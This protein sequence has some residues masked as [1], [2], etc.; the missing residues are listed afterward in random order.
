MDIENNFIKPVLLFHFSKGKTESEA[1][2][3][4]SKQYGP[5][6]I[7]MKTTQKWFGIFKMEYSNLFTKNNNSKLGTKRQK[8][9]DYI[10][11]LINTNFNK[12]GIDINN[13]NNSGDED[14]NR[15]EKGE[16]DREE[17]EVFSNC[18]KLTLSSRLNHIKENNEERDK[19]L[20]ALTKR[21]EKE[22]AKVKDSDTPKYI[23]LLS[24][25]YLIDLINNNP[26][27]S[28]KELAE[29][30][31]TSI[32][33]LSNRIKKINKNGE[34]VKYTRKKTKNPNVDR[35]N[36]GKPRKFTDDY[37]INLVNTN[38]TLKMKDLA[39]LAD[40]SITTISNRLR[41][42]NYDGKRVYYNNKPRQ[43]KIIKLT[44]EELTSLINSNPELN[45]S[46]I[47][48]LAG[49]SQSTISN[50]IRRINASEHVINYTNKRR[51]KQVAHIDPSTSTIK[52]K[53]SDEYLIDLV[54][55]NPTLNITELAKLIQC[56]RSTIYNRIRQI[57]KFEILVHYKNKN[58]QKEKAKFSDETL[59]HLVNSNPLL[60]M[61]ELGS[62]LG[63]SQ[64]T[65]S[66]RLKKINKFGPVAHY[67]NKKGVPKNLRESIIEGCTIILQENECLKEQT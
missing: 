58:T 62:I 42:I 18:S 13:D 14:Y 36:C 39:K 1:Y 50:K 19:I 23:T 67:I 26:E 30:A 59:I 7:T 32:A 40:S 20:Q 3:E 49:A 64:G 9:S 43:S 61:E 38:P 47:A 10:L 24:D 33:T 22:L 8:E 56:S 48:K 27:L 66:N 12:N 45:M 31:N 34:R 28:L 46:E 29:L 63:T 11:S 51:I 6:A 15:D 35:S 65:V 17:L 53:F 5:Y 41:Q 2:S 54:H 57:N 60:T 25:E 52:T 37:L 4:I 44:D 16:S 21:T 55:S